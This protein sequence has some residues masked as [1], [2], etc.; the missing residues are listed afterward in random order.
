MSCKPLDEETKAICQAVGWPDVAVIYPLTGKDRRGFS[1]W[2][3]GCKMVH[4][5]NTE[6][7]GPNWTFSGTAQNPTFSPSIRV[8][9]NEGDEPKCCHSFVRDGKWQFLNDCTHELAGQT[10]SM[11]VDPDRNPPTEDKD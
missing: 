9:W 1:M 2:C 6:G 7:A 10:V 4:T 8:R 11:V 3:P 5:V